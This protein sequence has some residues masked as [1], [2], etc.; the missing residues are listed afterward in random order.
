MSE[1][2]THPQRLPGKPEERQQQQQKNN[3]GD[4]GEKVLVRATQRRQNEEVL[5][6]LVYGIAENDGHSEADRA[7]EGERRLH[8]LLWGPQSQ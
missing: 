1:D 5:F 2:R 3:K 6:Q 4:K 7:T 8:S